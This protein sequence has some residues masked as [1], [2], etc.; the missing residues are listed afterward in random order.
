MVAGLAVLTRL[1]TLSIENFLEPPP[2]DEGRRCPDPPMRTVLPAL[3]IHFKGHYE[4]LEVLLAQIDTRL[5]ST[6]SE[7]NTWGFRS[8]NFLCSSMAHQTSSLPSSCVREY[9][10]FYPEAIQAEL[11]R[12]QWEC[13]QPNLSLSFLGPWLDDRVL[14]MVQLLGRLVT[15]SSNVGRLSSQDHVE[16]SGRL[17][18]TASNSC[19]S[20]YTINPARLPETE[21]G[22]ED[23]TTKMTHSV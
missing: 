16:L 20:G 21:M 11:D 6:T 23:F 13:P 15:M 19:H 9:F 4:C 2:P 14:C 7:W 17:I 22:R 10:F 8:P 1:R 12:P 18:W 5:K 3:S